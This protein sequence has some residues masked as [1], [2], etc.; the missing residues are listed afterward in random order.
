MVRKVVWRESGRTASAVSGVHVPEVAVPKSRL[1]ET[2]FIVAEKDRNGSGAKGRRKVDTLCWEQKEI[3][4][5]NAEW[6][7]KSERVRART[8]CA[9]TRMLTTGTCG[10]M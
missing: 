10:D 3:T 5:I 6:L 8:V 2:A 7:N 9:H 4:D 1:A